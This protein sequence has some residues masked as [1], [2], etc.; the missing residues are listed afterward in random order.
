[1]NNTSFNKTEN[2]PIKSSEQVPAQFIG[3]ELMLF[4]M[5]GILNGKISELEKK[6]YDLK[7]NLSQDRKQYPKFFR[8]F[9]I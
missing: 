2:V 9:T 3:K 4:E 6:Y 1:M 5:V 7:N 8:C